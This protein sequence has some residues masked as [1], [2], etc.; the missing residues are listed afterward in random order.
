MIAFLNGLKNVSGSYTTFILIGA[1]VAWGFFEWR[2]RS[3]NK[4]FIRLSVLGTAA[5]GLM[6]LVWLTAGTL[7]V[8][9]CLGAPASGRV[10][11]QFAMDRIAD[12]DLSLTGLDQAMAN[13]D[14]G[15][16]QNHADRASGALVDLSK[17][18]PAIPA[19]ITSN[20][21]GNAE[22][23]RADV[24]TAAESL[25]EAQEAIRNKAA[26][27]LKTALQKFRKA[28]EPLREAAKKA[29]R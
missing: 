11:R 9:F 18:P 26:A 3:E 23:L 10:A 22:A 12:I 4:P 24:R 1:A 7:L 5:V 29:A 8:S 19:L 21:P 20:E 13:Q 14:W 17:A 27:R 2:V 25:I 16:L 15:A 6:V 28:F